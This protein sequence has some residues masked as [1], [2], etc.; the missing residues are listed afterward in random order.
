MFGLFSRT[1]SVK[2]GG[3]SLQGLS[4][5]GGGGQGFHNQYA[6]QS[7]QLAQQQAAAQ[8]AWLY[9]QAGQ[10][11]LSGGGTW[12][13]TSTLP[14]QTVGQMAYGSLAPP[15][16]LG[17]GQ[18]ELTP[19]PTSLS[20]LHTLLLPAVDFIIGQYG[21]PGDKIDL[22]QDVANDRLMVIVNGVKSILFS[23]QEI[24]DGTYIYLF[25]PRLQAAISK[26]LPKEIHAG[27]IIAWRVWRWDGHR[28]KSTAM[29]TSWLPKEPMKADRLAEG[30]GIHCWRDKDDAIKYAR[31]HVGGSVLGQIE[32]WGEVIEHEA[33]YR[34]EYANIIAIDSCVGTELWPWQLKAIRELYL[35]TSSMKKP[36]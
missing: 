36:E 27:E 30:Y 33:G 22:E 7:A 19:K 21:T 12:S 28:L 35:D 29:E 15:S 11:Y 1:I 6:N 26:P 31:D 34:A 25:G 4:G 20:G 3:N 18:N 13:T 2:G 32:I 9:A 24:E 5:Q 23:R 8:Q 10:V 14:M 16:T 17:S